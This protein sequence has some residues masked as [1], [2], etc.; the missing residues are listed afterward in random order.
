MEKNVEV[1]E[2]EGALETLLT[3]I[4]Q[5]RTGVVTIDQQHSRTP[6]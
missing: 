4:D 3:T 5:Q 2:I 1:A 6:P